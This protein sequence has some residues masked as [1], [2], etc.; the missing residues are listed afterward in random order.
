M[1]RNY[2]FMQDGARPHRP[3]ED[4]GFLQT[5]FRDCILALDTLVFTGHGVEWPSNPGLNPCDNLLWG[6]LKD[7]VFK[8][9]PATL[10]DLRTAISREIRAVENDVYGDIRGPCGPQAS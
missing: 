4:L 1:L 6:C 8:G 7:R 9:A 10:Q 2:W 3:A 5:T